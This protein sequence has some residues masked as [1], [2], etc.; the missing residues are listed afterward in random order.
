MPQP[1]NYAKEYG[2]ALDQAYPHVLHFGALYATPNNGRYRWV[3][4]NT[5]EIPHLSTSGRV[6]AN[7]DSIAA[8]SRNFDNSWETKKLRNQRMWTT[9][10][11]PMDIQQTNMVASIQNITQTMN[12]EK[13][14]PEM[15]SYCAS[16]IY[17]QWVELG[18]TPDHTAIDANNILSVIDD[19]MLAADNQLMPAAGRILY[20]TNEIKSLIKK[21]KEISRS[22]NVQN[23]GSVVNREVTR[24]DEVEIAPVPKTLMM[25]DYNFDEGY[26]PIDGADQIDMFLIHPSAVLTPVSY[27]FARLDEPS[28]GSQGKY[29]YYEESFEDVFV[30]DHKAASIQFHTTVLQSDDNTLKSLSVGTLNLSPDFD[31]DTTAYTAATTNA[32]NTVKAKSNDPDASIK[33]K[34]GS[35][36][37]GSGTGTCEASA[38]WAEGSNTLTVE[39]TTNSQTKTYTVTVTKS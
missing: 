39:C 19:M 37:I 17:Q 10:V 6:P 1:I 26:V 16:Q 35:T 14:F 29:V 34:L 30:L 11:H 20:C 25:A 23:G 27:Q 36:V 18:F 3:N 4:G 22:F 13:K 12:E 24:I 32:T 2:Q 8:A 38:S 15:D 31:K 5:I 7:R 33:I 21:A 28:A 9:L